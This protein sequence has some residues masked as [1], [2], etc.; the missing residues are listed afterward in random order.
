MLNANPTLILK[1]LCKAIDWAPTPNR[2]SK[3]GAEEQ[4]LRPSFEANA[5]RLHLRMG[6]ENG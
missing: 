3:D 4:R 1:R 5:A 6:V 2:P